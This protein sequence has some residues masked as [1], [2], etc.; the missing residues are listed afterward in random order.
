[1][2]DTVVKNWKPREDCKEC[3]QAKFIMSDLNRHQRD[4]HNIALG[5]AKKY[6]LQIKELQEQLRDKR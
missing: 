3:R 2:T 4:Y 6:L 5:K 1:M